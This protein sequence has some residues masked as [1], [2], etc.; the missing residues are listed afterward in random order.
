MPQGAYSVPPVPTDGDGLAAAYYDNAEFAGPAA[1]ER[2]TRRSTS[3]G[4]WAP[5]GGRGRH[6][7]RAV[8]RAGR[9]QARHGGEAH[10]FYTTSDD[11]VRLWVDGALVIDHW[12]LHG[13]TVDASRPVVLE[14]E[15]KHDL[16]MEFYE[17]GGGATA[18]LE[19]AAASQARG[20]AG[21]AT[22][23][24]P[25]RP[26]EPTELIREDFETGAGGFMT[27]DGGW[28]SRAG[29]IRS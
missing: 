4:A 2:W 18:R 26:E 28:R 24:P 3:G 27:A 5:G 9:V 10:T 20:R 17:Y 11:G 16:R 19:W 21:G 7:C 23:Q 29:P 25:P 14:A 15:G 8:D 6:V 13:T 1:V 12:T 22:V